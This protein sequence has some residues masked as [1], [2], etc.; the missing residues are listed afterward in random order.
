M[1]DLQVI[2][3]M[4]A[5][6]AGTVAHSTGNIPIP[7]LKA[8]GSNLFVIENTIEEEHLPV[9]NLC[10]PAHHWKNWHG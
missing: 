2:F 9:C 5:A 8:D 6:G 10:S 1:Q 7:V 4:L 3:D